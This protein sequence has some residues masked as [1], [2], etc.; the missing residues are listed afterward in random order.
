MFYFQLYLLH[1]HF[2]FDISLLSFVPFAI[3]ETFSFF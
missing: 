2:P 3:Q 1:E